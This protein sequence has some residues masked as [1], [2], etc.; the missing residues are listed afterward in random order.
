MMGNF[1][2][3]S[4]SLS[5]CDERLIISKRFIRSCRQTNIAD[6]LRETNAQNDFMFLS[7]YILYNVLSEFDD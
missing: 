7:S 4:Y 5:L 2:N 6:V 1:Q 3:T